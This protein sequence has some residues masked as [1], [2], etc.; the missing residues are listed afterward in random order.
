MKALMA[1]TW[2]GALKIIENIPSADV[3]ERSKCKECEELCKEC[4]VESAAEYRIAHHI[5]QI[6]ENEQGM[7]VILQNN[8]R[9]SGKWIELRC[10]ECGQV[11]YSK[12]NYC[13]NCGADMR[14]ESDE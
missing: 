13:P 4:A 12:P 6:I 7:R 10:S 8:E 11:D 14:G 5:A 3:V 1:K 9:K 2:S